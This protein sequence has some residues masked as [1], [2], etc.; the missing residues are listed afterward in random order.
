LRPVRLAS[1]SFLNAVPLVDALADDPGQEFELSFDLPSRLCDRLKDDTADIALLPVVDSLRMPEMTIL[2]GTGIGC[3]G[4]VH[5]VKLF[6]AT[7][8]GELERVLVDRGSH[9]SVALLHVLLAEKYGR[10]PE[11]IESEP[12]P[13]RPLEAGTGELVI[14]DRCFSYEKAL[15]PTR[16]LRACD[17]GSMWWD[18]TGLPFVFAAWTTTNRHA[19]R[20]GRERL[21]GIVRRL[22]AARDAGLA[23][24]DE[25]AARE[26]ARG[27]IG[28]GGEATPEAITYYLGR[29]LR[30]RLGED[31][32]AGL[33][34]FHEYCVRHGLVPAGQ[35]PRFV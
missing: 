29:A 28:I 9:S 13:G 15:A 25:I 22:D 4:E 23:R 18:L 12:A 26:A 8:P 14:G 17:L 32:R 31:D 30:Y 16:D 1:V 11:F 24:L 19:E 35:P 7:P 21:E 20:I 2:W 5:S 27:R 6:S 33:D 3:R 34:R 10:V